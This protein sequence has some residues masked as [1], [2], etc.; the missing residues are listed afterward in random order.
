MP[1]GGASCWCGVSSWPWPCTWVLPLGFVHSSPLSHSTGVHSPPF[2]SVVVLILSLVEC[3][4]SSGV[5]CVRMFVV[6]TKFP[7]SGCHFGS[8]QIFGQCFGGL[9]S[10]GS[11]SV[12]EYRILSVNTEKTPAWPSGLVSCN[13]RGELSE[14]SGFN[15]G[16]RSY[17]TLGVSKPPAGG[18]DGFCFCHGVYE[19]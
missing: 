11:L 7:P 9:L 6:H 14:G 5:C 10:G 19:Y 12:Y 1:L 4:P 18:G 2:S 8:F 15:S 16:R 13:R 17:L 3:A